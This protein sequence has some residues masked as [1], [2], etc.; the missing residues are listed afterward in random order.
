MAQSSDR[1]YR[2]LFRVPVPRRYPGRFSYFRHTLHIENSWLLTIHTSNLI[3]TNSG[4]D[5]D[6]VQ[7][8]QCYVRDIAEYT[9]KYRLGRYMS[10]CLNL[11]GVTPENY[12]SRL[13]YF[14][15]SDHVHCPFTIQTGYERFM[16][17]LI[18]VPYGH[19][20]EQFDAEGDHR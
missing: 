1:T 18:S 14:H 19:G 15:Y 20:D 16:T 7:S 8:S 17:A 11:L 2:I 10:Q 6:K 3:L 9:K 5:F 12:L 4:P 13:Y